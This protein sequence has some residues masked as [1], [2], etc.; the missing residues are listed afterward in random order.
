LIGRS[1]VKARHALAIS[2][3]TAG[4]FLA[5]FLAAT[6]TALASSP[7]VGQSGQHVVSFQW[8]GSTSQ[9]STSASTVGAFLQERG[10]VVGASDLVDPST[11]TPLTDGMTIEYR[12]ALPVTISMHAGTRTITS[13][14]ED[15]GALL[16]E[17]GVRL[18]SHDEVY[19]GLAQRL[20]S[21]ETV[22]I[23]RVIRWTK[24]REQPIAAQ[25]I[26]KINFT[27]TPGSTRILARGHAGL[28]ETTVRFTQR[29]GG[30]IAKNV[31]ASRIVQKPAARV[32]V[33]GLS[34]YAAFVRLERYGL[35]KTAYVAQA[36]LQ[37]VATA[38]TAGCPGCSGRTALGYR[39]G[40]GIVA[41]DPS[42]IPLGTRLYIPGYGPAIAGDTGGS[43]HGLRI[44][45][46]FNS[47]SDA[48]RFG[49][50]EVTVFRLK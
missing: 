8:N 26:Q 41:V 31:I 4:L 19:P 50:R 29:D 27:L 35:D 24:T 20:T 17:Q 37:M 2:V 42:V 22:R 15:V 43:I 1:T 25:T 12:A 13:A 3:L 39:A 28:R 5:G 44:D 36:A 14:A 47:L 38:Y 33:D 34:E 16:E 6:S 7:L 40:H 21:G 10:I 32:V 9:L 23:V 48:L 11:D 45:L 18:G 30:P 49:R 46:G